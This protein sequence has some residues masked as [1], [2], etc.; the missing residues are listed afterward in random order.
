M[1]NRSFIRKKAKHFSGKSSLGQKAKKINEWA[2]HLLKVSPV[3]AA[4]KVMVANAIDGDFPEYRFFLVHEQIP[5]TMTIVELI[6]CELSRIEEEK[7][8]YKT[9][10]L[11]D[12]NSTKKQHYITSEE[13]NYCEK[14]ATC[15]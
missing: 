6:A 3:V 5:K 7:N 2:L 14:F 1:V 10:S 13:Y 9:L 4:L 15:R 12:A 8:S 11:I